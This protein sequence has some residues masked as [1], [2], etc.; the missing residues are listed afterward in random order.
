MNEQDTLDTAVQRAT[1]YAV[2]LLEI[3]NSETLGDKY[4][5]LFGFHGRN[6]VTHTIKVVIAGNK[7]SKLQTF[8]PY[9][10]N[11]GADFLQYHY[12]EYQTTKDNTKLTSIKTTLNE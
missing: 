10:I 2:F 7:N 3:L 11:I 12:L 6:P 1:E 5:K 4:Y 8:E 9:E